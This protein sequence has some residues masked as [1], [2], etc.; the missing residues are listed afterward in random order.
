M[1]N[2]IGYGIFL[3]MTVSYVYYILKAN[4]LIVKLKAKLNID[5]EK[6]FNQLAHLKKTLAK[7]DNNA[8]IKEVDK[9]ELYTKIS[10]LI[11]YVG[12]SILIIL[13]LFGFFK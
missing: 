7:I 1:K 13:L 6:P 9:I 11:V 3:F 4:F 8:L 2:I 5:E 10:R 12:F